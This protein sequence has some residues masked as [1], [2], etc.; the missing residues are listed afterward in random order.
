MLQKQ[1][2]L[3]QTLGGVSFSRNQ[4]VNLSRKHG[5][6]FIPDLGG[7]FAWIFHFRRGTQ[8]INKENRQRKLYYIYQ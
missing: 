1:L 6:Q 4:G 8:L 5:G 2:N 3:Y 7:Q